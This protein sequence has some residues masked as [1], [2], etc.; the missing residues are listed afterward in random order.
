[1]SKRKR[2]KNQI[3]VEKKVE[4]EISQKEI[5]NRKY[6]NYKETSWKNLKYV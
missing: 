4:F 3:W 1:M 6:K 5:G 2:K